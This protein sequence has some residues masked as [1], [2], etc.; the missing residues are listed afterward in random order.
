MDQHVKSLT[1]P[2]GQ[3]NFRA[4]A[5]YLPQFHPTKENDEWWGAGFTEWRNTAR[6]KPLFPGHHQPNLPA[7]LGFYDLRVAEVREAQAAIARTAGIEG[8][9]YWHYW[10]AGRRILERPFNEVLSSGRPNFPFCLAW[11]N[12][13]WQGVW[14]GCERR[15]LI[16]QTYPGLD[17]V[18]A[19]FHTLLPAFKDKRYIKVGGRPLFVVYQPTQL[20]DQLQFTARWNE[21]ARRNGLAGIHFVAHLQYSQNAFDWRAHGFASAL[22]SNTLKVFHKRAWDIVSAYMQREGLPAAIQA[23]V[24]LVAHRILQRLLAWP[25]GVYAYRD[26]ALFMSPRPPL[27]PDIYPT[28]VPNW[29]NSPRA[30]KNGVI[31]QGSTPDMFRRHLK[32][33]LSHLVERPREQRIVFIKSWNEWAEGNYLE[34]DLRFGHAYLEVLRDEL[35]APGA[36]KSEA[37]DIRTPEQQLPATHQERSL[38]MVQ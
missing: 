9:C 37:F 22:A 6:A 36:F 17:D 4:I 3:P 35:F 7:D 24:R 25:A 12:E 5:L 13:T 34:P 27:A 16:E 29:D 15:V 11:A 21:L 23:T 31:L 33:I 2:C 1:M 26:A 32:D 28:A 8:F 10:F 19:H 38:D 30:G 18:D 14:H 20:P